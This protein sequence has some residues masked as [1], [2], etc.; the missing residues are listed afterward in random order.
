MIQHQRI[1]GLPL[2]LFLLLATALLLA[3]CAATSPDVEIRQQESRTFPDNVNGIEYMVKHNETLSMIA[4]KYTTSAGNWK[5]IAA[6]NGIQDP[7]NVGAGQKIILP[8]ELLLPPYRESGIINEPSPEMTKT[9]ATV[10]YQGHEAPLC[11]ENG[12]D[13]FMH[14]VGANESLSGIADKYTGE[15]SNWSK[16]ALANHITDPG[17]LVVN[18]AIYIPKRLLSGKVAPNSYQLTFLTGYPQ[19]RETMHRA[20]V[21]VFDELGIVVLRS[22]SAGI[23]SKIWKHDGIQFSFSIT[24]HKKGAG[25]DVAILCFVAPETAAGA[26]TL[27]VRSQSWIEESLFPAIDKAIRDVSR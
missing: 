2:Q 19:G 1:A 17:S 25:T 22:D 9:V 21:K 7:R 4:G 13:C 11:G 23:T 12:T 10:K 14:L 27:D 8:M 26:A 6:V 24:L 20:V 16:I 5:K 3:G 18:Q 15:V